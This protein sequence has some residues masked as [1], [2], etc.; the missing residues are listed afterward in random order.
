MTDIEAKNNFCSLLE[1]VTANIELKEWYA[2]FKSQTPAALN[3]TNLEHEKIIL[4]FLNLKLT[5]D[6]LRGKLNQTSQRSGTVWAKRWAGC[7][8]PRHVADNSVQSCLVAS[9]RNNKVPFVRQRYFSALFPYYF[10]STPTFSLSL[11]LCTILLPYFGEINIS[12]LHLSPISLFYHC[13]FP[14][15][16]LSVHHYLFSFTCRLPSVAKSPVFRSVYH[17]H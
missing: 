14:F 12:I 5:V 16:S 6:F 8:A 11:S 2:S 3:K 7:S 17:D 4:T 1:L 9:E 13:P 10:P 15:C